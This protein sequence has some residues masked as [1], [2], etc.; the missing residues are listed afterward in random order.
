MITVCNKELNITRGELTVTNTSAQHFEI[1]KKMDA[2]K[3]K[4][5]SE[6]ALFSAVV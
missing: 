3:N 4:I 2:S 1:K 5:A 6:V